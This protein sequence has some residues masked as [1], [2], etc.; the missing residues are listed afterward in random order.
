[1]R[2]VEGRG[3]AAP[4]VPAS[5]GLSRKKAPKPTRTG[6]GSTGLPIP[7]SIKKSS[8]SSGSH[9]SLHTKRKS[10]N[11]GNQLRRSTEGDICPALYFAHFTKR[12][13]RALLLE[14]VLR[15]QHSISVHPLPVR[16]PAQPSPA[17]SRAVA[18]IHL[19]GAR[20]TSSSGSL[21][22]PALE[23]HAA[24]MLRASPPRCLKRKPLALGVWS[25]NSLTRSVSALPTPPECQRVTQTSTKA[26][27]HS[28][29]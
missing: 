18:Q 9:V 7:L 3:R 12:G 16:G 24:V 2:R 11:I 29:G 17:H 23:K 5:S 14:S 21:S 6:S 15:V 10:K 13:T 28:S 4:R 22:A 25:L 8:P 26:T 1:M 27:D 19:Y 20:D